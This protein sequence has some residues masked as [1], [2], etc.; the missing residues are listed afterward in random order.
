MKREKIYF[1]PI[2]LLMTLTGCPMGDECDVITV[3]NN[4]K[5]DILYY[6][7][8]GGGGTVFPDTI[9]SL[10]NYCSEIESNKFRSI[11]YTPLSDIYKSGK[12]DTLCLFILDADTV[13]RYTWEEIRSEYKILCRYDLSLKDFKR[14]KYHIYY[15]PTEAMKDMKMYPPYP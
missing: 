15:P 8:T 4:S 10:E 5:V 12:T 3:Y 2:L 1:I 11:E 14:L 13:K 9:L 6:I 7:A